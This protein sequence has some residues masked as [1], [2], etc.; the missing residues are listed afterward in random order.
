MRPYKIIHR[1]RGMKMGKQNTKKATGYT[2]GRGKIVP[3][4]YLPLP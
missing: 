4:L 2:P 1:F 3:L